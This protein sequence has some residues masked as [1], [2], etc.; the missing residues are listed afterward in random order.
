MNPK[1][2]GSYM[3]GKDEEGKQME[4]SP[5]ARRGIRDAARQRRKNGFNEELMRFWRFGR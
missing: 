4:L 2:I 1:N 3:E 5:T